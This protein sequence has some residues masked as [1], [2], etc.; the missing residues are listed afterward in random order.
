[1]T[2]TVPVDIM[3]YTYG[4]LLFK[5]HQINIFCLTIVTVIVPDRQNICLDGTNVAG[6]H[7]SCFANFDRW[8]H[9]P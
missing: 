9:L 1:M 8:G 5:N 7:K 4:R 2:A 6:I 3:Y